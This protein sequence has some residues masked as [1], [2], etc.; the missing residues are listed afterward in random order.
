MSSWGRLAAASAVLAT[1]VAIVGTQRGTDAT[2]SVVVNDA[3]VQSQAL[4]SAPTLRAAD[5]SQLD[6]AEAASFADDLAARIPVPSGGNFD[7]IR[8]S[9]LD[10]V[11]SSHD[12]QVVLEYNA[13]C[14]WFRA[15]RDGRQAD[16]ARR[17]ISDI[18]GWQATR[19]QAT[20]DITA[21]VAADVAAGGGQAFDDVLR[22]CDAA[23]EREVEYARDRGTPPSR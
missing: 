6:P 18:P 4:I 8:W 14:Q 13:A 9:E 15:L 23:H 20:A 3:V 12:I 5:A 22:D 17:I 2:A 19:G 11:I 21:A 7:G 10:G 1:V 16:D